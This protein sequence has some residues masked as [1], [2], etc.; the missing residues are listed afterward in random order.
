MCKGLGPF[1]MVI[2]IVLLG[3]EAANMFV[4]G[5]EAASAFCRG[6]GLDVVMFEVIVEG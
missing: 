5:E 3:G 6:K 4:V 1:L 2:S